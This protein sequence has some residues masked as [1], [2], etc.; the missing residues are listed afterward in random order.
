MRRL[1]LSTGPAALFGAM[2]AA[3]LL[4][5]LPMRLALGWI[6]LGDQGISARSV[7]GSVWDGRLVE[8]RFGDLALG[9]LHAGLSPF[10]LLVGRARIGLSDDAGSIRGAITISRHRRGLDDVTATL[11]TGRV[12]AP[13][14]VTSLIL[15]DVTIRFVDDACDTAE[16]RVRATLVGD[17]GG[18]PLPTQLSGNARCDGTQLLLP[19]ASQAGTEAVDLRIT[20]AGRYTAQMRI[21][22]SDPAAAERLAAAGFTPSG[23]GYRLSIEGRF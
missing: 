2:L 10:A 23:S 22:P 6:G 4:V 13:L 17:A 12:F 19:L 8:A 14:P 21:A 9:T 5:F 16:G 20:G 11:P 3:A 18:V 7:G 1:R 15:E